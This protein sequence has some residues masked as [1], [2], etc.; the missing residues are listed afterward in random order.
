M[1]V[2]ANDW[3]QLGGLCERW[4]MYAEDIEFCLRA[5]R[6]GKKVALVTHARA[7]HLIGQSSKNVN[8][9]ANPAW[10]VNLFELYQLEFAAGQLSAMLWK[11]IVATGFEI[12]ALVLLGV[13]RSW[14]AATAA[15]GRAGA[16]SFHTYA[17]A[18]YTSPII[19]NRRHHAYLT[20][21]RDG[22]PE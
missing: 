2:R 18:L 8:G 15:S 17:K 9:R 10:I 5:K 22:W 11:L 13:N 20:R 16:A 21:N 1:L 6:F 4:F 3:H 19:K 7:Q 12:R 14:L